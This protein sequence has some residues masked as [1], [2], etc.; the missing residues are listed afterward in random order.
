VRNVAEF[1]NGHRDREVQE[2]K[3]GENVLWDSQASGKNERLVRGV[4]KRLGWRLSDAMKQLR[5]YKQRKKK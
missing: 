4:R 2:R 1:G 3:T 5:E